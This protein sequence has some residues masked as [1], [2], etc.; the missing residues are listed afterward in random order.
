[1][2]TGVFAACTLHAFNDV[3]RIKELDSFVDGRARIRSISRNIAIIISAHVSEKIHFFHRVY[4]CAQ[5][6]LFIKIKPTKEKM[7]IDMNE[8]T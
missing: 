5:T 1:M 4:S 3:V 2:I 7:K 6:A 8:M